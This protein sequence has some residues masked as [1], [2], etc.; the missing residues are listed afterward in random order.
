MDEHSRPARSRYGPPRIS[1]ASLLTDLCV[2]VL[3]VLACT[4][5]S[6]ADGASLPHAK[7]MGRLLVKVEPAD[8]IL[9]LNYYVHAI[10]SAIGPPEH[11]SA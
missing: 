4:S 1:T 6:P 7:F 8:A 3:F 10:E 9:D 2:G 5:V 11:R